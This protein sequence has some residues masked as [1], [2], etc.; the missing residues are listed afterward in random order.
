MSVLLTRGKTVDT[1][2]KQILKIIWKMTVLKS[3]GSLRIQKN[4]QKGDVVLMTA[5]LMLIGAL[6]KEVKRGN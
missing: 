5:F 3:I 4:V 6:R 1:E 2:T